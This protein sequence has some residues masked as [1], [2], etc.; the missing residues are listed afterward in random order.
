M[1]LDIEDFPFRDWGLRMGWLEGKDGVD[2]LLLW[3]GECANCGDDCYVRLNSC[4]FPPLAKELGMLTAQEAAQRVARLQD[5]LTL[6]AALVRAHS[7]AGSPLRAAVDALMVAAPAVTFPDRTE[8][9]A[10]FGPTHVAESADL[11][12]EP[13]RSTLKN[14][15]Q[16]RDE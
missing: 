13:L 6:L 16:I 3:Q 1:S 12:D 4:H 10:T 11:F 9:S 8:G 5:R 15:E 7:P 14:Q 2:D